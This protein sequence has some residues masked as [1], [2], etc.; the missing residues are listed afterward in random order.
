VTDEFVRYAKPLI[1]SDWPSVPL[2]DGLL[3]FA[4]LE[5]I[6]AEQTLCKYVPQA[7]R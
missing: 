3:R 7:Q 4:R 2:V 5:P 6:F 1:G